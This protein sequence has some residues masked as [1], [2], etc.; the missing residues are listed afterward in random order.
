M[1]YVLSSRGV[2]VAADMVKPVVDSWEPES[3]S[4][5]RSFFGLVSYNYI[6]HSTDEGHSPE[7]SGDLLLFWHFLHH[8][9][10]LYHPQL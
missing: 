6:K 2:G 4:E 10:L 7:T 8:S 5:F 1:G 9:Q 3:V